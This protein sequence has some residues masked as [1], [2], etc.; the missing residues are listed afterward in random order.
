MVA[1]KLGIFE[2]LFEHIRTQA[3]KSE[4]LNMF[5]KTYCLFASLLLLR[6]SVVSNVFFPPEF[7]L[8]SANL[9]MF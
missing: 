3:E 9:L 6:Y 2:V 4:C 7:F 8:Q 1:G 5:L